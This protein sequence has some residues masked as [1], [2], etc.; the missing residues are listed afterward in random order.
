[1]KSVT[2]NWLCDPNSQEHYLHLELLIEGLAQI[3]K[4][5]QPFQD[6]TYFLA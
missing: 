5:L 4:K 3:L 6:L 1:M 2:G